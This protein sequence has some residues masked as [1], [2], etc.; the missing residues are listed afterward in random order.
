MESILN[1]TA[2]LGISLL[3]VFA[4][5]TVLLGAYNGVAPWMFGLRRLDHSA[6]FTLL[7]ALRT[8]FDVPLAIQ[9]A[10]ARKVRRIVLMIPDADV[11]SGS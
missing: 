9:W 8:L 3:D 11:D 6:S 1:A 7:W 5:P 2:V 10:H 4:T